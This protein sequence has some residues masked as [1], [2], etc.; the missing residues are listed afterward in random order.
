METPTNTELEE[1]I[2][3]E[4]ADIWRRLTQSVDEIYDV[5]RLWNKG[6]GDWVYEYKYRRGG[7][8]LCTF[9]AK[10]DAAEILIILGKSE[11]EKF[12]AQREIFSENILAL[13]DAAKS[14]H[15]G[16]WLWIPL[17]AE[18][19]FDDIIAMLKIKRRPNRK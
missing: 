8:T 13:Y 12:D 14:Y 6:F 7:K 16:K 11:R 15:D 9:Y 17:C 3:A 10:K 1:L 19:S 4:R 18:L 2:G 5:D